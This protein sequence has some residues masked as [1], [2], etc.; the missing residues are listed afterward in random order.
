VKKIVADTI[1]GTGVLANFTYRFTHADC[2]NDTTACAFGE[3]VPFSAI[4][5]DAELESNPVRDVPRDQR[6]H[7][8]VSRSALIASTTRIS[9]FAEKSWLRWS[10]TAMA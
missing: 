2:L 6:S 7:L 8:T 4:E 9:P 1:L 5:F 3:D 10:S